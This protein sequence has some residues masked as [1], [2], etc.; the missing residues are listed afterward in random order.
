MHTKFHVM[1]RISQIGRFNSLASRHVEHHKAIIR[2]EHKT[3]LNSRTSVED[4]AA[5]QDCKVVCN[6]LPIKFAELMTCWTLDRTNAKF[7]VALSMKDNPGRRRTMSFPVAWLAYSM[8]SDA[9]LPLPLTISKGSGLQASH[10]CDTYG[11]CRPDHIILEHQRDNLS[12]Q[13]C[14]GHLL[15]QYG[16]DIVQ[17]NPCPHQPCCIGFRLLSIGEREAERIRSLCQM[18]D[19]RCTDVNDV[20][21]CTCRSDVVAMST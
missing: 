4:W 8:R 17:S 3:V 15:L 13:R 5:F 19:G 16:H 21:A 2:D 7:S 20:D 6:D 9:I 10:L 14:T 18:C 1:A 11:C 12:R